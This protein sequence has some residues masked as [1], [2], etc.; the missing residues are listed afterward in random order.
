MCSYAPYRPKA[1]ATEARERAGRRS[2][3]SAGTGSRGRERR[4]RLNRENGTGR[5]YSSQL[6]Q[7]IRS[8]PLTPNTPRIPDGGTARARARSSIDDRAGARRGGRGR[9]ESV[10]AQYTIHQ[11]VISVI[12]RMHSCEQCK[13]DAEH[14]HVS[15]PPPPR[16]RSWPTTW[17]HSV[18]S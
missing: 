12:T 2:D 18:K 11:K 1:R 14:R 4:E 5:K 15:R 6:L 16:T 8:R 10:P 13:N 7:I 9:R 17:A 3:S